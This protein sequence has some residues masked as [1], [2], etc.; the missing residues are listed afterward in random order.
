ML[1]C[2]LLFAFWL[3]FFS[4]SLFAD[5]VTLKNGDKL[6]GTVTKYDGKTLTLKTDFLG[7]VNVQWDAITG[8][9]SDQNLHVVTKEGKTVVGTVKTTDDKLEVASAGAG[10]V[11]V[12]KENITAVRNDAEQVAFDQSQNPGWGQGWKGGLNLGFALTRGNSAAKSFN[13]A[14]NAAR[15]G[16]HDKLTLYSNSIYATNDLAGANPS[17][18][19]NQL[20]GGARYDHDLTPK[21][22]AFVNTDFLSDDLQELDLR[23]V[24]GGGLGWHAIKNDH[25]T[26]DLLGGANYTREKYFTM[27]NNF[28]AAQVGDEFTHKLGASTLLTQ[29]FYFFPNLSDTGE[30]RGTFNIGTVTKMSKWLGWQNSFQDIYVSNPPAGTKKNDLVFTTGLNIA[31]AH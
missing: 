27:T 26:L 6:T 10:T 12:P 23:S 21:I 8:L 1:R 7:E 4:S 14:F 24:F 31:F 30:Y 16:L 2:H 28:A 3:L 11:D 22:F 29:N 13:L 17:T 15:K 5:Q 9:T 20:G 18:T 19:A 25:T